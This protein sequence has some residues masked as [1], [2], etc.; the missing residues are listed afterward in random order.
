MFRDC[1]ACTIRIGCRSLSVDLSYE[2]I[3]CAIMSKLYEVSGSPLLFVE[4]SFWSV[5]DELG[6][7]ASP[8]FHIQWPTLLPLLTTAF[9]RSGRLL[10]KSHIL[11][12]SH[13]REAPAHII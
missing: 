2:C 12:H 11:A 7:D 13:I 5:T 3:G 8:S 1:F 4:I 10:S 6:C 9:I